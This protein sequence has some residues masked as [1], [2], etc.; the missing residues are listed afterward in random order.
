MLSTRSNS[1][2]KLRFPPAPPLY[3]PQEFLFEQEMLKTLS[4][5]EKTNSQRKPRCCRWW[6]GRIPCL[7]DREEPH[8]SGQTC[9]P[10]SD[11]PAC[12]IMYHFATFDAILTFLH[13]VF[14]W[15]TSSTLFL[16]EH[17]IPDH[18]FPHLINPRVLEILIPSRLFLRF[19]SDLLI[20]AHLISTYMYCLLI[21][22]H[23]SLYLPYPPMSP[24]A[25]LF[26]VCPI[27]ASCFP[28]PITTF[29]ISAA[30]IATDSSLPIASPPP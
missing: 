28:D 22:A 8:S 15:S 10:S 3:P 7:R 1:H 20:L 26:R 11:T 29:L 14:T 16:F 13:V 25:I 2:F 17:L 5:K 6:C 21:S 19:S 30:P 4:S 24:V 12:L 23:F 27:A 18:I 9:L